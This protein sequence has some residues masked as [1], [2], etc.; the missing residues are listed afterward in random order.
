MGT[1]RTWL[2]LV[3]YKIEHYCTYGMCRAKIY[4]HAHFNS[5]WGSAGFIYSPTSAAILPQSQCFMNWMYKGSSVNDYSMNK[6]EGKPCSWCTF[7][8]MWLTAQNPYRMNLGISANV[9]WG[10]HLENDAIIYCVISA[11]NEILGIAHFDTASLTIT[12]S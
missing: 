10:P 5:F 8:C 9:T 3:I 4:D 12:W 6:D 2:Y 7:R 11:K 1:G